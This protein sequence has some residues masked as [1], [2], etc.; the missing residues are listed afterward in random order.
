MIGAT[1]RASN[2]LQ[3]TRRLNKEL[4]SLPYAGSIKREHVAARNKA[5]TSLRKK[6]DL[7]VRAENYCNYRGMGYVPSR[8]QV[9]LC[10][11]KSAGSGSLNISETSSDSVAQRD[12]VDYLKRTRTPTRIIG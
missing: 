5:M 4:D 7:E 6:I 1:T 3:V 12:V 10:G 2:E 9:E 11:A 8:T